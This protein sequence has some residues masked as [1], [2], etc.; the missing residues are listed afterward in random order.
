MALGICL[1]LIF[2]LYLIDKHN[3]WRQAIKISICLFVLCI[4]CVSGFFGWARYEAWQEARQEAKREAENARQEG[5]KRAKLEKVCKE[6]EDKHPIGSPVDKLYGRWDDGTKMPEGGVI[7]G[8]PEGCQGP[9]EAAYNEKLPKPVEHG[10]WEKYAPK[11]QVH[12]RRV[13]AIFDTDI[14]TAEYGNLICGHVAKDET[15]TLLVED[16]I[17]VK[18]KT[19]SGKVGWAGSGAFRVAE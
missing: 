3:R 16:N 4:L 13:K 19:A 10:P 1:L 18:V 15:V 6:W 14:T 2:I 11:T 7:L 8:T 12:S 17:F 9:L 5:E